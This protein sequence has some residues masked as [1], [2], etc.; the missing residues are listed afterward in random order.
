MILHTEAYDPSEVEE[1]PRGQY[2]T[3]K[4]LRNV[5]IIFALILL[6]LWPVYSFLKKNT[7]EHLCTRNIKAIGDALALYAAQNEDHFPMAFEETY[8]GSGVPRINENGAAVCWVTAIAPYARDESIFVCP[9][10][11]ESE[12]AMVEGLDGKTIPCTYGFYVPYSGALKS[13]AANPGRTIVLAETSNMG[14]R[15][16]YDPLKFPDVRQDGFVI[17]LDNN[18]FQPDE[19]TTAVTRL[20]FPGTASGRFTDEADS[21]HGGGINVLT[22]EGSL[23]QLGPE[24]AVYERGGGYWGAPI[25]SM[26]RSS[27]F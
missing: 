11:H 27:G 20:A 16:T 5:A 14:A 23:M 6:L 12:Y 15:E 13:A 3:R 2:M 24:A 21:R 17:G 25:R 9:S 26:S 10:A 4:D 7:E 1:R 18:Q 8:P 19:K 22:V